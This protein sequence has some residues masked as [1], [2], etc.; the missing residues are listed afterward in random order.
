MSSAYVV[1][2]TPAGVSG[3]SEVY[4]LNKIVDIHHLEVLRIELLL[5]L[6]AVLVLCV[7]FSAFYII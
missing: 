7:F 6:F 3:L 5:F 1:S 4:K 2:E